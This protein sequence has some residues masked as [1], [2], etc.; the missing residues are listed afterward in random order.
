MLRRRASARPT[1]MSRRR[2]Q[3]GAWR[4]GA[5]IYTPPTCHR[6]SRATPTA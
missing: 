6:D 1:A 5:T 2:L 3:R 4:D